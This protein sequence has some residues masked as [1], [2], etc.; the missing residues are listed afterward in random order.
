MNFSHLNFGI[1]VL[2]FYGIGV[3]IAF[4]VG[5][6]HFYKILKTKNFSL[7]FF[8]QCF[9][10]WAF[11]A[12]L[13]GRLFAITL[14]HQIFSRHGIFSFFVFWDGEIS[15]LGACLGFLVVAFFDCKKHNQI[16]FQWLDLAIPSIL[17]S[18]LIL[19]ITNFVTGSVYGKETT[20]PWGIQYQTSNVDL[21][22]VLHPISIYAFLLH[23]WIFLFSKKYQNI[24]AKLPGKLTIRVLIFIFFTDF[25]LQFFRGD[26]SV[27]IF[28]LIRV[29]QLV[30]FFILI[31][32]F[33]IGRRLAKKFLKMN[34]R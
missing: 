9:G 12:I 32:L 25:F 29:E 31:F 1:F 8:V 4:L 20:M 17:I 33:Y 27:K 14:D 10:K 28:D 19:D 22:G 21:L 18:I 3:A 7:D 34:R 15:L 13:V 5:A 30:D 26:P 2:K 6:W 11:I 24:F 16:F 23:L